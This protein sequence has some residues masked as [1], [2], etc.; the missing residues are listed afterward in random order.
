MPSAP[1]TARHRVSVVASAV[2]ALLAGSGAAS[3][4]NEEDRMKLFRYYIAHVAI[5]VCDIDISAA[6]QKR[7]DSATDVLERKV[8]ATKEEM[9]GTFKQIK[10]GATQNP[11]GFC[12][13]Y[14]PT[15]R[16]TLSE[17]D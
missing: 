6:H 14:R 5:D 12:E 16:Q 17:F 3:A 1:F 11:K 2:F 8:G 7:F 10:T 15:A 9:D 4:Q 13:T